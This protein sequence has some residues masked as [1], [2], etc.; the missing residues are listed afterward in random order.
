M[1]K[2]IFIAL[3]A[4]AMLTGC[5]GD[6]S[7]SPAPAPTPPVVAP[8][9]PQPPMPQPPAQPT[10]APAPQPPAPPA[11]QP[12]A[13][14]APP[15]DVYLELLRRGFALVQ[16]RAIADFAAKLGITEV[17]A[18]L[19]AWNDR[20]QGP[21]SPD[22]TGPIGVGSLT[23]T[24]RLYLYAQSLQP[25]GNGIFEAL[26]NGTQDAVNEAKNWAYTNGGATFA[27]ASYTGP[28]KAAAEAY[29][30]R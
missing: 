16:A 11:P 17:Y 10:P 18:A 3:A 26:L 14:T 4:A 23:P 15:P 8:P 12:P 27:I 19:A 5:Q 7:T 21:R 22:L 28:L 29:F 6:S 13:P 30:A 25:Q 20:D 9:A 24:D 1:S 2:E